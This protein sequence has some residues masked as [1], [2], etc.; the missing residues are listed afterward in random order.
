MAESISLMYDGKCPFQPGE[1]VE[2]GTKD[3]R[4]KIVPETKGRW[5][6]KEIYHDRQLP[7]G[8]HLAELVE[9]LPPKKKAPS[10]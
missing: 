9:K 2:V 8:P 1:D 7:E 5:I 4:G 6:C 10:R 3:S